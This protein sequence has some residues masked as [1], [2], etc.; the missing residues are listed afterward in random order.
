[1]LSTLSHVTVSRIPRRLAAVVAA[2]ALMAFGLAVPTASASTAVLPKPPA[3]RTIEPFAAYVPA[4]SCDPR[5]KV[6]TAALA[7]LLAKT[8]PSVIH[9]TVRPC[10]LS[11]SEHYQ[12]RA[13]DWMASIS[14][15]AQ[16]ADAAALFH[17]LF[18]TDS[19][20]NT[21][22]NFRRL[23]VMYLVYDNKIFGSWD[24]KW[25]PYNNC[26][27]QPGSA[28][29]NSCHR[30]HVHISLSWEGANQRTS[31]WT[32]KVVGTDYGPCKSSTLNWAGLPL[33]VHTKPCVGHKTL[34]A[35]SG[36]STLYK[37]VI[38][39]SG[40]R[41]VLGNTGGAV[42]AVQRV[43]GVTAD[44]DFGP[45]TKAALERW[46]SAHH[47]PA[48]GTADQVTWHTIMSVV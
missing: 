26:A 3:L 20:G 21:Y 23:G 11:V 9:Y 4:D 47:I 28:Y 42:V 17:W 37:Q 13:I 46:Q 43:I 24:R 40:A 25:E 27:N 33:S 45:N 16:Y 48:N 18:A 30:T 12:G 14:N 19:Y 8:Y 2:A 29:D 22:S 7:A 34:T 44:G 36:A 31:F 6:G 1:V 41:A 15:S 38:P 39:W 5:T 10:D 32:G 35:P